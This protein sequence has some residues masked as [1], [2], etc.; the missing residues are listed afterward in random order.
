MFEAKTILYMY[1]EHPLH[2]GSGRGLTAVDLPIQRERTTGYPMVQAS[3][4]KGCLRDETDPKRDPKKRLTEDEWLTIFGPETANAKDHAGA[5]STGDARLLLFPVRSLAGVFAWTTSLDVLARF[6]REA[7]ILGIGLS[8]ELPQDP[9]NAE[10]TYA[11]GDALLAGGQVVLEEYS[12]APNQSQADTVKDI[13]QWIAKEALPDAPEY[14]YFKKALPGRLCILPDDVLRDF[15]LFATEVQTHIK[16]EPETKTVKSGAL[17]TVE[18]L[19]IDSLMYIPVMATP[20]RKKGSTLK[21][22]Q[23]ILNKVIGLD[24][25]RTSLGGDETTGQGLVALRF[26]GNQ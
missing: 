13:G 5:L 4:I 3:G 24:L 16:I 14:D 18:S 1:I 7:E 9:P 25:L 21:T 19:P 15:L 22:A 6:R 2:A 12:F 26:G 23:E 10:Q 20:S 8:W 17:W 11:N